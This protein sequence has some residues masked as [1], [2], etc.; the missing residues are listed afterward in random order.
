MSDFLVFLKRFLSH[1]GQ[2]GSVIPS[3]R[4]LCRLMISQIAWAQANVIVELGPGTGVFTQAILEHK[5]RDTQFLVVEHDPAFQQ[6]LRSRFPELLIR[7]EALH[8]TRYL[9]ELGLSRADVIISG[10]PF[11]LFPYDLRKQILD[12]VLDSLAPGGMF[13]TFQYSLQLYPELKQRFAHVNLSFT[14][15]NVPPAFV[16]TCFKGK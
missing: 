7:D 11:A 16:Y 12:Q 14:P 3:S 4:F 13:V 1:P 9:G 8:L 10:L 15:F 5:R 6:I 2:V